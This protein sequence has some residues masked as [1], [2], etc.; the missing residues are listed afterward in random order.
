MRD[1]KNPAIVLRKSY[2]LKCVHIE[3]SMN[4]KKNLNKIVFADFFFS[5]NFNWLK[6]FFFEDR[7]G[8]AEF[9]GVSGGVIKIYVLQ[10]VL[11]LCSQK[12]EKITSIFTPKK[13]ATLF[14]ERHL[15]NIDPNPM[16]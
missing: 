13:V 8:H 15:M 9:Y 10:M 7:H 16:I 5:V 2:C 14:L 11:Y 4:A 1:R 12:G 6:I 3:F